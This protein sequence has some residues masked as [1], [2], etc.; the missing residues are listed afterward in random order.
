MY[1]K[2][3]SLNTC[4]RMCKVGASAEERC[5]SIQSKWSFNLL[6]ILAS[7]YSHTA[8]G[9]LSEKRVS[10]INRPWK[11]SFAC[12]RGNNS[13]LIIITEIAIYGEEELKKWIKHYL[14]QEIECHS[15]MSRLYIQHAE[16]RE[17]NYSRERIDPL[18][19]IT[20]FIFIWFIFI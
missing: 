9:D 19:H 3:A 13:R 16:I 12:V 4:A 20:K 8:R 5:W 11:T 7:G 18:N 1:L 2:T 15:S 14:S 10:V 6:R 17:Q